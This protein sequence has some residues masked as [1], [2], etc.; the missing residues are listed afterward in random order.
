MPK[1]IPKNATVKTTKITNK[2]RHGR[3]YSKKKKK[4]FKFEDKEKEIKRKT[5][6]VKTSTG[7]KQ[8]RSVTT[9]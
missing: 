3:S 2:K 6:N 8:Q 1:A 4:R 5:E 7:C 9:C